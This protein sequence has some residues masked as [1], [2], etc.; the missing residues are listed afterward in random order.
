M[1]C[2]PW[3]HK[4]P[5]TTE[6][7][8]KKKRSLRHHQFFFILFSIFCSAAMIFTISSSRLFSHFSASI[9]HWFL[10]V[11]CSSLFICSLVLPG[12]GKIS[13]IFST[14]FLKSRISFPIVILISFS[15]R[16][17]FPLHLVVFWVFI[18]SIHLGH[19]FLLLHPDWLSVMWFLF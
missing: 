19:N 5:D 16:C 14:V 6:Q 8:N 11:Y 1:C 13:W 3:S 2:S 10:L 7:L 4:V 9:I 15:G 17:L 18:L 12:L